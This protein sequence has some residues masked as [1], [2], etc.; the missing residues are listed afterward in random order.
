TTV[1]RLAS[2]DGSGATKSEAVRKGLTDLPGRTPNNLGVPDQ[3]RE[4][5][6]RLNATVLTTVF[7]SAP[8]STT[9]A[10]PPHGVLPLQDKPSSAKHRVND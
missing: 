10:H 3:P 8:E 5:C 7:P 9:R 1:L 6:K 4:L 2:L